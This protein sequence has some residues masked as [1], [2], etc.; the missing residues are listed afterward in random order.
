MTELLFS[1][2]ENKNAICWNGYIWDA[3]LLF[4]V[5]GNYNLCIIP[6][7]DSNE[8]TKVYSFD[9]NLFIK[10][11]YGTNNKTNYIIP[12]I[13]NNNYYLIE[14]CN[15]K[16]SINNILKS[17]KYTDLIKTPEGMHCCGHLHKNN[18][19]IVSDYNNNLI[20]IWDLVNKLAIKEININGYNCYGILPWKDNYSIIT[21]SDGLI[22]IDIDKGE[23]INK[24]INNNKKATNL[25]GIQKLKSS[26]FGE[27]II[28]SNTKNSIVLFN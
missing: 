21:C 7:N 25:S 28:C 8:L 14:C 24:I 27:S 2:D 10:D 20:R 26:Y 5:L 12:W 15:S 11:I 23:T 18:F 17:E 6:S 4:K 9:N 3:L 1:C 22:I 19:L 16:I 13:Y